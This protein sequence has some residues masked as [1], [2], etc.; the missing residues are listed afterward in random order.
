MMRLGGALALGVLASASAHA[1]YELVDTALQ[2][3]TDAVLAVM[4]YTV[5]PDLTTSTL[6]ISSTDTGNPQMTM[7]QLAGKQLVAQTDDLA[8]NRLTGIAFKKALGQAPPT[9]GYLA[10]PGTKLVMPSPKIPAAGYVAEFLQKADAKGL[11]TRD[12]SGQ[13]LNAI[14]KNVPWLVGGS[15][16]LNPSTKTFLK[17][18]GAGVFT[19]E[20]RAG[21][22]IHFG[23]REHGMTAIINGMALTNL[24]SFGS[25][26]L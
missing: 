25:S 17:F 3:R 10:K 16:D 12:S 19:A 14:A 5:V 9:L 21:R 8:H 4:G 13:V 7:S 2:K 15:A 24:R 18:D 22:N 20:N 26:F 1:E 23:V 6:S 11:A